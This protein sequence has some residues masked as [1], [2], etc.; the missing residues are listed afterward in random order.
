MFPSSTDILRFVTYKFPSSP[1]ELSNPHLD[2]YHYLYMNE[3]S[4]GFT[5]SANSL[6][7]GGHSAVENTLS[8]IY[9]QKAPVHIMYNDAAVSDAS[10]GHAKGVVAFDGD[11]G[12]WMVHSVPHFPS[13]VTKGYSF[14]EGGTSYGQLI[15]CLTFS[16]KDFGP[17][18]AQVLIRQAYAYD[19]KGLMSATT[20][21]M[22]PAQH[23]RIVAQMLREIRTRNVTV[24]RS[25]AIRELY[26]LGSAFPAVYATL[27]AGKQRTLLFSKTSSFGANFYRWLAQALKVKKLGV[28]SWR[29]GDGAAMPSYCL[30]KWRDFVT[31]VNEFQPDVENIKALRM[32]HLDSSLPPVSSAMDRSKW[33]IGQGSWRSEEGAYV[34]V[35]DLDRMVSLLLSGNLARGLHCNPSSILTSCCRLLAFCLTVWV[36]YLTSLPH[37]NT[38]SVMA[39][40]GWLHAR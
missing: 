20:R 5:T 36:C 1:K 32:E 27:T 6:R 11:S 30:A 14:P 38:S 37:P 9:E 23:Q 31:T 22:V 21:Q 19:T 40:S 8:Q 39:L 18:V 25:T 33:A 4:Q 12:F 10:Y 3:Q 28:Q 29:N 35:G 24:I 26:P 7:E 2:G 13:A 16:A 17:I 15:L 34:C